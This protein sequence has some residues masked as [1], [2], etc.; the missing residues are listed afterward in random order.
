LC[1]LTAVAVA[2]PVSA[3]AGQVTES[4]G[5]KWTLMM[6]WDADN[7]LEFCTEFAMSTWEKALS[8]DSEINIV[9]FIDILS[10]DGAWVYD[11]VDGKRHLVQTWEELNSSDPATLERFLDYC[12]DEFPAENTML[13]M[14]DHGY[15]WRGL[16]QDETNGDTLM[17]LDMLATALENVKA[18]GAGVDLLAFDA[19]NMMTIEAIYELK[20]AVSYVVGS[21]SMVPYD[22]LPYKMFI[23]D[24]VEDPD[25]TPEELAI[26][27]VHEYV[28]YYSSKKDYEHIMKYSQDFATC[29]AF[30]MSKV[31]G[32]GRSFSTFTETLE[33]LFEHYMRQ[34]EG[35][36]GSALIGP[37]ANIASIEWG[38][39]MI[40]YME[41]LQESITDQPALASA[42]MDFMSAY[43]AALLAE[44]HSRKYHDTA[45]GLTVNF[46]PSLSNYESRSWVWGQQFVY[47]E[48]GLDIVAESMWYDCL[49]AYYANSLE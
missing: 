29:S 40:E 24:L 44:D 42:I 19:C 41:C 49:M 22:G 11:I 28:L 25:L 39:D 35:A 30:D 18:R 2:L 10:E 38:I 15:G 16:C 4:S 45:H 8:D 27:I 47:H 31:D 14:Q 21:E 48:I 7:N 33:P 32:L 34:I 5:K 12:V 1:L 23:T 6:Y 46:P 36:R 17:S 3:M 9:A 20:D 37:W 13:V 26:N 43:D